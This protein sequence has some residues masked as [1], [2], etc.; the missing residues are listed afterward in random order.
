M[1]ENYGISY[2][3]NLEENIELSK[4]KAK[5]EEMLIRER[6]E[7]EQ[8]KRIYENLKIDY[9][10]RRKECNDLNDKFIQAMTTSKQNEERLEGELVRMKG[11]LY[12][13]GSTMKRS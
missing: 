11:V 8:I 13:K 5:L 3:E 7:K 1:A 2:Q 4:A 9:E 6:A 10:R 12:I